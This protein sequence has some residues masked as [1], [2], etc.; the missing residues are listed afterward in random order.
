MNQRCSLFVVFMGAPHESDTTTSLFRLLHEAIV[1]DLDVTVWT[2][3]WATALTQQTLGQYKPRNLAGWNRKYPTTAAIAERLIAAG[4]GRLQWL[5]CRFCMEDRG[6]TKQLDCVS[7]VPSHKFARY[8]SDADS[9][10]FM[11]VM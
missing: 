8:L 1:Q 7:I 10:L 11:G 3:G 2:C 9:S 4:K 6:T 5:V